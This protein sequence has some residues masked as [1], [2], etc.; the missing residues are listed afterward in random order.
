MSDAVVAVLHAKSRDLGGFEVR[1]VLPALQR[2][3][4]GPFIFV[5]QMGPME[6]A[7]DHG[8]DVRPHPHVCLAT[9]TYLWSG[10][11]VHRDSLG[12]EQAIR[13]GD[14][15]WMVAGRGIVHSERSSPET[16]AR[17]QLVHGLQCWVALPEDQEEIAP[18]FVHHP[19]KDLPTIER[20][21]IRMTVIAGDAWGERSPVRVL[22]RTLY[23]DVNLERGAELTLPDDHLERALYVVDGQVEEGEDLWGP[24]TMLVFGHGVTAGVHAYTDAHVVLFGGEPLGQR[25]ID[26]N[27]VASSKERII[28]ARKEWKEQTF[29]KIPGDDQEFIPLPD[30]GPPPFYP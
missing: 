7:P 20:E 8:L 21:G 15:N 5:D 9:V 29:P 14:V 24:G 30:N 26:W 16:R 3:M 6:L 28:R 18:S 13:P 17:G 1:R 11:I 12:S 2:R 25:F 27:F 23:V 19:K 4:V 10:E 22:S